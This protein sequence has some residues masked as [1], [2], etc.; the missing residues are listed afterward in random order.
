MVNLP[1]E[2]DRS[3]MS[4]PVLDWAMGADSVNGGWAAADRR[5]AHVN[6]LRIDADIAGLTNDA[7]TAALRTLIQRHPTLRTRYQWDGVRGS[8]IL[9]AAPE[10]D[11]IRS[12]TSD[13]A[14][15]H[16]FDLDR[17]LP[18]IIERS[19]SVDGA[20]HL[21]LVVDH[22]ATDRRGAEVLQADLIALLQRRSLPAETGFSPA[23]LAHWEASP[24]GIEWQ[25]ARERGWCTHLTTALRR[26][27]T[28][29]ASRLGPTPRQSSTSLQEQVLWCRS[30]GG[31]LSHGA[32]RLRTFESA[33][34]LAA[35][36]AGHRHVLDQ[37]VFVAQVLSVNRW[38][39]RGRSSSA[40]F[41]MQG[42]VILENLGAQRPVPDDLRKVHEVLIHAMQLAYADPL[43]IDQLVDELGSRQVPGIQG[44]Y[45]N[46]VLADPS[47]ALAPDSDSRLTWIEHRGEAGYG[48]GLVYDVWRAG[49]T[50]R[51]SLRHDPGSIQPADVTAILDSVPRFISQVTSGSTPA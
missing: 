41:F 37:R 42:P 44:V 49:D 14:R 50:L 31:A 27:E 13:S 39:R 6:N 17:E 23:E 40:K 45:Y 29:R 9:H 28:D 43:R 5:D 1:V 38:S 33:I 22:I 4:W 32:S 30:I 11:L 16:S 21:R 48:P 2:V 25:N 10:A 35:I 12:L 47:R 34:V 24:D 26:H 19:R 20:P 51:I 18:F 8:Q 3:R 46:Y 15:D 7:V 36:A